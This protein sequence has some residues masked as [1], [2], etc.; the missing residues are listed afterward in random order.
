MPALSVAVRASKR[1]AIIKCRNK[2]IRRVSTYGPDDSLSFSLPRSPLSS[3]A[4]F[5]R[6]GVRANWPK[7]TPTEGF[8]TAS[9][10]GG[11]RLGGGS[12]AARGSFKSSQVK[13]VVQAAA[14]K[15]EEKNAFLRAQD[16]RKE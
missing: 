9:V 13:V 3:S 11:R 6:H 15:K 16:R 4:I 2:Q 10:G 1:S 7:L 8:K 14:P 5:S 12:G